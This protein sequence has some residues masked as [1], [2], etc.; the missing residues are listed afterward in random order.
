MDEIYNKH[1]I[2]VDASNRVIDGYSDAFRAPTE[3]AIC[4]NEQGGYQFRLIIDGKPTEENPPL[5]DGFSMIPLYKY[6]D[7]E[8][9]HR[10]EEELAADREVWEAEQTRQ[11]RLAELRQNLRDTDYIACKIAEGAAK[12]SDYAEVIAQRQAWRDE[13]NELS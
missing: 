5:F 8:V 10:T 11:A 2:L 7:G 9:K 3:D 4:I 13:I 1:Y 12:K 6:E